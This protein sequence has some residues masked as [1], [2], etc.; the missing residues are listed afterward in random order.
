[1]EA[2]LNDPD[3]FLYANEWDPSI[4]ILARGG[5]IAFDPAVRA[6]HRSPNGFRNAA[7]LRKITSRNETWIAL[8]YYP[9]PSWPRMLARV[10]FWNIYAAR[11][12]GLRVSAAAVQGWFLGLLGLRRALAKREVMPA[13]LLAK[14]ERAFWS[15]R[16][17][18]VPAF[19][20]VIKRLTGKTPI[21]AQGG[22]EPRDMASNNGC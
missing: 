1:V 13:P 10:L 9:I 19:R 17:V 22:P 2:G 15:F 21:R 20:A 6:L 3:F 14:Y 16:P 4:R 11:K 5:K 12:S 8:K 18:L 7:R